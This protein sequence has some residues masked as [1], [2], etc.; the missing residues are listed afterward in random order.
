MFGG[1]GKQ[2]YRL[3]AGLEMGGILIE[4]RRREEKRINIS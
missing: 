3:G 1:G 2:N 4:P